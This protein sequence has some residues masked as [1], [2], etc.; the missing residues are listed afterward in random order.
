MQEELAG[1][2]AFV[3]RALQFDRKKKRKK[4][5]SRYAQGAEIPWGQEGEAWK[6]Q[7]CDS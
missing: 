2:L 5:L 1:T 7:D 6:Q 4:G 3:H